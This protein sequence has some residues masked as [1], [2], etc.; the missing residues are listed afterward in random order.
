MKIRATRILA[1]AMALL[2]ICGVALAEVR[3]TANVWMRTGPGLKYEQVTSFAEG[4]KLTYLGETQM[5]DRPVA[6]YKVTDGKNTGWVSSK[7]SEL[8]G[9]D[10]VVAKPT[11]EVEEEDDE[12]EVEVTPTPEPTEKLPA[13]EVGKLFMDAVSGNDD[14][15][16]ADDGE[17]AAQTATGETVELSAYYLENLVTAANEIGL[18][19]YREVQS[20]VPYQY[21]DNSLIIA[22]NQLVENI[23]IYGEGYEL[24]GVRVGM[25][26]NQAVAC[27]TAAGLDYMASE[28]GATFEHRGTEMSLFTDADGHDSCINLNVDENNVITMIDWSSY[29]G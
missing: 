18:V 24:F 11:P 15:E 25:A 4:K 16:D 10:A 5:D 3:T 9:E 19:S 21:Y 14:D 26:L 28:D 12:V 13:L 27:M 2:L 17:A 1:A 23:V 7:Y 20:E 29:T 8:I 6:W 22:G